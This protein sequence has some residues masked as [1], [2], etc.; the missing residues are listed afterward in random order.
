MNFPLLAP[1]FPL[2][3]RPAIRER[4]EFSHLA[5]LGCCK[6]GRPCAFTT[7]QGFGIQKRQN[8][9]HLGPIRETQITSCG[10]P[11][12]RFPGWIQRVD[13]TW[14]NW[15]GWMISHRKRLPNLGT[16]RAMK[17]I[18]IS[19]W[20]QKKLV[21]NRMSMWLEVC[22]KS[23]LSTK[24]FLYISSFNFTCHQRAC[25]TCKSW[26]NGKGSS[27]GPRSGRCWSQ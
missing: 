7:S 12:K 27:K 18:F 3:I 22:L 14:K 6:E 17:I 9:L 15:K 10:A 4:S 8:Q 25:Q 24:L 16:K 1:D 23:Q 19:W 26:M 11:P 20:S 5:G 2:V 21:R 13:S